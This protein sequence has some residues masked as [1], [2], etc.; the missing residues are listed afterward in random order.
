MGQTN[1]NICRVLV[2]SRNK[3]V[4]K[5]VENCINTEFS[6]STHL[7]FLGLDLRLIALY[8]VVLKIGIPNI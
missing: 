2:K 7:H 5:F 4:I 8:F 3:I 1:I 6:L